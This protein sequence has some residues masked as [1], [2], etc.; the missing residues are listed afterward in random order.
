MRNPNNVCVLVVNPGLPAHVKDCRMFE[1]QLLAQPLIE[2]YRDRWSVV[3]MS[4]TLTRYRDRA[5]VECDTV[6]W[7]F[8]LPPTTA[9]NRGGFLPSPN[10]EENCNTV[11]E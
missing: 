11:T 3:R 6:P 4:L 9:S 1:W 2:P 10:S 8:S 7:C 5:D